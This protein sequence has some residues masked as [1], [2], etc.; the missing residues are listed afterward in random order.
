[1]LS[2][3]CLQT[4]INTSY[5]HDGHKNHAAK[6]WMLIRESFN[7][8]SKSLHSTLADHGG[9]SHWLL[10]IL[11]HKFCEPE[12]EHASIVT[13][14]KL[15]ERKRKHTQRRKIQ[16]DQM[17]RTAKNFTRERELWSRCNWWREFLICSHAITFLYASIKSI[18][19][20]TK[21]QFIHWFISMN[22]HK[23]CNNTKIGYREK[24]IRGFLHLYLSSLTKYIL[25]GR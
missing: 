14:S 8:F 22:N 7:F 17:P 20:V 16:F 3:S 23:W 25:F 24:E 10:S 18:I 12:L 19:P 4:A 2:S 1:M 11:L 13:K 21:K 9:K 5:W 6:L 15:T